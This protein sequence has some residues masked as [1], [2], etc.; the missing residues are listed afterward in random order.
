MKNIRFVILCFL[1][2][3]FAC[4]ENKD[5]EKVKSSPLELGLILDNK[6]IIGDLVKEIAGIK[7]TVQWKSFRPIGYEDAP[8]TVCVQ[9]DITRN[10]DEYHL[11]HEIKMQY[12]LNRETGFVKIGH[13]EV[14]SIGRS[15]A[16]FYTILIGIGIDNLR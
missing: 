2:F 6:Y 9:I 8:N 3:S 1:L 10:A 14:D 11:K 12:L 16:D 4:T 15:L 5:I 13:L 7:G